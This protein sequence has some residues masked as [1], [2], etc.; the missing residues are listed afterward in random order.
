M[1][2]R[3]LAKLIALLIGLAF[4]LTL[5]QFRGAFERA[6]SRRPV[7]MPEEFASEST[8]ESMQV[9]GQSDLREGEF[10]GR[11]FSFATEG[12]ADYGTS[13]LGASD[14]PRIKG[15]NNTRLMSVGVTP[16]ESLRIAPPSSDSAYTYDVD[17]KVGYSY[18][19]SVDGGT[20]YA[21]IQVLDIQR[22]E[23][24]WQI[25]PYHIRFRYVYQANGSRVLAKPEQEKA[26]EDVLRDKLAE[27][28]GK[29]Q[30]KIPQFR[31]LLT[32]NAAEIHSEIATVSSSKAREHLETELRDVAATLVAIDRHEQECKETILRLRSVLR[33]LRMASLTGDESGSGLR[34]LGDELDKVEAEA[35]LRLAVELGIEF[36]A[37]AIDQVLIERKLA[38]L[39]GDATE[40]R[41]ANEGDG[42]DN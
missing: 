30:D 11:M 18:F 6:R 34:A 40:R 35:V 17:A 5:C 21:K 7:P 1:E 13:D 8:E 15:Q 42:D 32:D 29:L 27:L 38:V 31:K 9:R 16:F 33:R 10:D 39:Q 22:E 14:G 2:I 28:E 25:D 12:A 4:L 23:I 24:D 19:V 20:T 3:H 26:D 37:G 36:G 41:E